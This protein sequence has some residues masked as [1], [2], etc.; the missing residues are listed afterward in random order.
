MLALLASGCGGHPTDE[1]LLVTFNR[2]R[3]DLEKLVRMF[4]AD[5][6]LG[7]VGSGFTRPE[8]PAK[9]SVNA[10]RIAEYRRLCAAVGATDCIEGYDA[11]YYALY[12]ESGLAWG[13]IP[14]GSMCQAED[15]RCRAHP[16]GTTTRVRPRRMWSGL[17][18][19]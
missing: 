5:R 14:S 17:S 15:S 9:V 7:R 19:G 3:A 12:G 11:E 10:E 18:R 8:D 6:G 2:H 4:E 13:R 16:K 1:E